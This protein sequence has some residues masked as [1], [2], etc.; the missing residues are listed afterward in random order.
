MKMY[1][2]IDY[3]SFYA[4]TIALHGVW[5]K[6]EVTHIVGPEAKYLEQM[7]EQYDPKQVVEFL[8]IKTEFPN[9]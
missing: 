7:R 4:P 8:K 6:V 2:E 1:V 9:G 3:D 5:G